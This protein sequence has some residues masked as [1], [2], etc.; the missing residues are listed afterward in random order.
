[1]LNELCMHLHYE[2]DAMGILAVSDGTP[3]LLMSLECRKIS[4]DIIVLIVVLLEVRVGFS[5]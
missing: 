4:L 1:M 3:S 5:I 2:T